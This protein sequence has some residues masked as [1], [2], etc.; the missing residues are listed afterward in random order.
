M[1]ISKG[2]KGVSGGSGIGAYFQRTSSPLVS[3][4]ITIP[5]LLLYNFGL[6]MPGFNEMNRADFLTTFIL[7][8]VGLKGFL[9]VNAGLLLLSFVALAFS[10]IKKLF[11]FKYW[12]LLIIEGIFYGILLGLSAGY[13]T[14][15]VLSMS[16]GSEGHRYTKMQALCVASGAGYWEELVFR[17]ICV[18]SFLF[19]SSK[20]FPEAT[21][22][23]KLKR[24]V[25]VVLAVAT[26][27]VA[28]SLAH[29]IEA[30]TF[31]TYPFVYRT[32]A[33]VVFSLIYLLRGFGVVAY[34]H[35]LYDL[36]VLI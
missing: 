6:M 19:L 4:A 5:L 28:F 33:G 8:H 17:V 30:E 15:H 14:S 21:R 16:L 12:A 2:K 29:F 26:S 31:Q 13:L 24:L 3:F 25:V 35:F 36:F 32:L 20:L 27:S 18:G 10:M 1:G 7:Q 22:T 23:A 34:T 11:S 9:W